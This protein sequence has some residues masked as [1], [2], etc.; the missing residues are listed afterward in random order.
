MT[1]QQSIRTVLTEKYA[2][3]KG[4]ASRSEFWWFILAYILGAFLVALLGSYILQVLY[5]LALVIPMAAV[6]FRRMQ[7]TG[8]PGWYYFIPTIYWFVTTLILPD[9]PAVDPDTGALSELPGTGIVLFGGLIGLIGMI[10][11]LVFL[12]WLTRPSESGANAYG[13]EPTT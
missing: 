13:P 7:D 2:A 5:W 12:W 6:G 4:R 10:I 9:P 11:S 8:R 3:F 1:F